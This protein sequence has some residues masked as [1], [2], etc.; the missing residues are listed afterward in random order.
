MTL[1]QRRVR[2]RID[3]AVRYDSGGWQASVPEDVLQE[4]AARLELFC[5]AGAV[6]WTIGVTMANLLRP[7]VFGRV[8]T[9]ASRPRGR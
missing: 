1:E 9:R 4:A 3:R 5:A 8:K 6:T 7:T 2:L